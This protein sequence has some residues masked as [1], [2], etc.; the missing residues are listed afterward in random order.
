MKNHFF[1]VFVISTSFKAFSLLQLPGL[2]RMMILL[3]R[4]TLFAASFF[5]IEI[6]FFETFTSLLFKIVLWSEKSFEKAFE[7]SKHVKSFSVKQ[8]LLSST[9][10]AYQKLL[11]T[12]PHFSISNFEKQIVLVESFSKIKSAWNVSSHKSRCKLFLS[13]SLGKKRN[14]NMHQMSM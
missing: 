10:W 14:L 1:A 12:L 2:S 4:L 5:V 11:S 13:L 3:D 8:S 9:T 6:F 7:R